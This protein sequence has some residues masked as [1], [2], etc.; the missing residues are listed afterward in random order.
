MA[1]PFSILAGGIAV[2]EVCWRV[3]KYLKDVRT[4]AVTVQNDI[5]ALIREVEA[6]GTINESI[7]RAFETEISRSSN[8]SPLKSTHLEKLW[9]HTGQSLAD[10]RT[11]I[12]NLEGLVKDIYGK[13]GPKVVG[14]IDGLGKQS[15]NREKKAQ[16]SQIRNQLSTYQSQLQ[17]LLS[18][19]NVYAS[20][21]SPCWCAP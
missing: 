5:D 11:A 2:A 21:S 4:A 18:G 20:I 9:K 8:L 6:L 1:E 3:A 7:G 16:L 10:C 19:I 12:E 14:K 13:T 15:R 17:I